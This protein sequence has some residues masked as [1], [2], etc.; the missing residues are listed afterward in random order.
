MCH[1]R[2]VVTVQRLSR[3]AWVDVLVRMREMGLEA[4]Q[5]ELND[6]LDYLAVT[7]PEEWPKAP[8]GAGTRNGR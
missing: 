4:T 3:A 1:D 5:R 8:Q 6:V 2:D 7:F